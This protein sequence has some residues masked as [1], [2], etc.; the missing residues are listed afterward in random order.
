MNSDPHR[1]EMRLAA[2][3]VLALLPGELPPVRVLEIADA[4][5]AAPIEALQVV[6]NGPS[7]LE[8]LAALR[9]RAG[10]QMLVG[11]DRVETIAQLDSV[12]DAGADFASSAGDFH[13]PLLAHAR[14][15]NFLY[16]PTVHSPGQTLIAC[17]AGVRLQKI[18][19]DID[20]E[21]M[22]G[23]QERATAAGYAPLYAINQIETELV[24]AGIEAG[25]TL[26]CV[27]DIYLSP[28]QSMANLITR[29]R[30]AR[31][32]WLAATT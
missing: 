18:R 9:R 12:I 30:Q 27:N 3:G 16:I 26:V 5:L 8:T 14:K 29:A 6:P 2:V 4:L 23:M 28:Q 31:A 24:D 13:L 10:D 11:A 19:D 21:G 32:A 7:T 1:V 25:A 17:R 15:R 20:V 22:E